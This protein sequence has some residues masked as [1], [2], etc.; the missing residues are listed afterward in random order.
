MEVKFGPSGTSIKNYWHQSRW[1]FSEEQQDIHLLTTKRNEEI[2]EELKVE[3]V[4]KKLRRYKSNWLQHVPRMNNNRMPKIMLNY[5]P[6]RRRQLG[7][8][9]NRPLDEAET[10]L[11]RPNLW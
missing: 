1:N 9:L 7:R 3:W 8:P 4:H 2:L 10:G 6:K 11:L 5:R